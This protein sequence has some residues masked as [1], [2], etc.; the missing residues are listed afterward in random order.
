VPTGLVTC[1]AKLLRPCGR[2]FFYEYVKTAQW[3]IGAE[4]ETP[5]AWEGMR[6]KGGVFPVQP[7]TVSGE[8]S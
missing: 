5:E 1:R 6:N 8:A 2:V 3:R 4:I 7:T